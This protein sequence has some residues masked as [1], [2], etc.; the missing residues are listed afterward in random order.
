MINYKYFVV[1]FLNVKLK[2]FEIIDFSKAIRLQQTLSIVCRVVSDSYLV[3][4]FF[5]SFDEL[6][7]AHLRGMFRL[8]HQI[9]LLDNQ[10]LLIFLVILL[11]VTL[12]LNFYFINHKKYS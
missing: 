3:N 6:V 9:F 7:F 4:I 12:L 10:S 11:I 8:N 1:N 5:A 2:M